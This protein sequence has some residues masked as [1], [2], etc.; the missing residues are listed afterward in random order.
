MDNKS[1]VEEIISLNKHS[2][3]VFDDKMLSISKKY[4]M[5]IS[6]V[7]TLLFIKNNGIT[8][9]CDIVKKH[10]YSKAY[11]SKA[12]NSL[13][14]KEYIAIE[15]NLNDKRIQN[16]IILDK[17]NEILKD[18]DES[19]KECENILEANL[20]TKDL[21]DFKNII[22]KIIINSKKYMEGK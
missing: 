8:S 19:R 13:I 11:V 2:K 15:N 18:I 17:S 6:E 1:L 7:L 9:A 14:E 20:S 5:E 3:K 4:D 16:I 21:E 10:G 12:I 22:N